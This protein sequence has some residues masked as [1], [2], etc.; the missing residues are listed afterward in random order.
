MAIFNVFF[1]QKHLVDYSLLQLDQREGQC[2]SVLQ[3][4]GEGCK[5]TKKQNQKKL[6]KKKKKLQRINEYNL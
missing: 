4:K 2:E 1:A 5:R 3:R 6:K